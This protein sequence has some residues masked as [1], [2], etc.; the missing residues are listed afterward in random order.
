[1][2]N[3]VATEIAKCIGNGTETLA[4]VVQNSVGNSN[5]DTLAL[6]IAQ[7]GDKQVA[8]INL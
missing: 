3:T 2:K 5:D 8:A 1:M 6:S 7:L 4:E